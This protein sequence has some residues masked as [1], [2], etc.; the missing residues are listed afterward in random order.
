[1]ARGSRDAEREKGP[2]ENHRLPYCGDRALLVELV[3]I[4]AL[5]DHARL[6]PMS[7]ASRVEE[8]PRAGRK[9]KNDLIKTWS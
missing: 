1:V 2:A 5:R 6:V 7:V 9:V 3:H 8:M 4:A